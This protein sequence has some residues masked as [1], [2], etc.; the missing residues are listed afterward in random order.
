[1]RQRE[2]RFLP[3]H[4]KCC[5]VY[6]DA[7]ASIIILQPQIVRRHGYSAES[8]TIV[9]E[10]GYILT[11]H[12]IPGPRNGSRDGQPVFLQHGLLSSSADWVDADVNSLGI[13]NIFKSTSDTFLFCMDCFK[14]L[15]SNK[16]YHAIIDCVP[17]AKN[18][19]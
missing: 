11:L 16:E 18:E 13:V 15:T 7:I 10:D 14:S 17:L 3:Q 4:G 5:L 8:H 2:S 6:G 9:T 12:R 19:K 1:M